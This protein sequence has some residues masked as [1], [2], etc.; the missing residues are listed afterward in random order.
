METVSY[1]SC[2]IESYVF[3][4]TIK[5]PERRHWRHSIVFI[6][7]FEHISHFSLVIQ[8]LTLNI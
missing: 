6:I 4:V 5:T 2:D 8:L 7:H 1:W 3:K